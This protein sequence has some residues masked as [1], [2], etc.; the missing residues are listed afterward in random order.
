MKP[1][2][3]LVTQD[4]FAK[5]NRRAQPIDPGRR[6]PERLDEVSYPSGHRWKRYRA[7]EDLVLRVRRQ[8]G[9]GE[10]FNV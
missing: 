9:I 2:L 5:P 3:H 10:S 1:D 4:P 7:H 8:M 6:I